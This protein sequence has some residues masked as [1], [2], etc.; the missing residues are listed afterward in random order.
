MSMKPRLLVSTLIA[1][2][3]GLAAAPKAANAEVGLGLFLGEPL[4][5]TVKVDLS[6]N[7]ALEMLI[8]SDDW[9]NDRGRD[10]YGHVTFLFQLAHVDAEGV[11]IPFR[12]GLGGSVSDDNG[13]DTNDDFDADI[14]VR[15]PFQIAFRFTS[16][17]IELYIELSLSMELI[18]DTGDLDLDGGIGFRVYF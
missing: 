18:D 6:H 15:A 14:N 8:G 3:L 10:F 1:V 16:V 4:G 9:D 11:I 17:P 2:F 5:F 7:T 13:R 12:L